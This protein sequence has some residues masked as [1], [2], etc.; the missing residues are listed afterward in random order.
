MITYAEYGC[1][2]SLGVGGVSWLESDTQVLLPPGTKAKIVQVQGIFHRRTH[3]Q[4]VPAETLKINRLRTRLPLKGRK[5]TSSKVP[6]RS[7]TC[8]GLINLSSYLASR[9]RASL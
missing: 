1:G 8:E 5:R 7:S 9:G 3:R 2:K 6:T 4:Q